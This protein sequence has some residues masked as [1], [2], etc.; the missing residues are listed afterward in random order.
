VPN[1]ERALHELF[2]K[3]RIRPD[4]EWFSHHPDILKQFEFYRTK[5]G[6]Y[7]PEAQAS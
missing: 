1:E 7:E 2:G 4:R 5:R 3:H 6:G